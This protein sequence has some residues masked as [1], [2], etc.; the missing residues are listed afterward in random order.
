MELLPAEQA[1]DR[2]CRNGTAFDATGLSDRR[3][4]G[5]V[6]L[7]LLE[8]A[9]AQRP[10]FKLQLRGAEVVGGLDFSDRTDL[11]S[12]TLELIGCKFEG[13]ING[14]SARLHRL[15]I[16][17]CEV[18]HISLNGVRIASNLVIEQCVP[19]PGATLTFAARSAIIEGNAEFSDS[20]FYSN[21]NVLAVD[22]QEARIGGSLIAAGAFRVSGT[23]RLNGARIDGQLMLDGADLA[24]HDRFPAIGFGHSLI[25]IEARIGGQV[26]LDS[27]SLGHRFLSRGEVSFD[28]SSVGGSF[29]LRGASLR[30]ADA[31]TA[32]SARN[33]SVGGDLDLRPMTTSE[34]RLRCEVEGGIV[35]VGAR[36]V[37]SLMASGASIRRE[38]GDVA[39][40]ATD[41]VVGRSVHLDTDHFDAG[42]HRFESYGEVYMYGAKIGGSLEC[43]GSR[44]DSGT[45]ASALVLANAHIGSE[46]HFCPSTSAGAIKQ[47]TEIFGGVTIEHATVRGDACFATAKITPRPDKAALDA[48]AVTIGG[49]LELNSKT[50]GSGSASDVRFEASGPVW[51]PD[52]I[53]GSVDAIGASLQ[54]GSQGVALNLQRCQIRGAVLLRARPYQVG[55]ET[56][57]SRFEANG[58]VWMLGASIGGACDLGGGRFTSSDKR[59]ALNLHNA[60]VGENLIVGGSNEGAQR[61]EFVGDANISSA[62]VRGGLHIKDVVFGGNG[63]INLSNLIT[64]DL[65]ISPRTM[66]LGEDYRVVLDGLRYHKINILTDKVVNGTF[67][68]FIIA[69]ARPFFSW[70]AKYTYLERNGIGDR[71]AHIQSRFFGTDP[72]WRYGLG[73][74]DMMFSGVR[75][76][77]SE[78]TPQPFMQMAKVLRHDGDY[79]G[80]RR[81]LSRKNTIER[82][83]SH[84]PGRQIMFGYWALFDYGL[85][86]RRA[87]I[88]LLVSLAIGALGVEIARN[89]ASAIFVTRDPATLS[90]EPWLVRELSPPSSAEVEKIDLPLA[91]EEPCGKFVD[92]TLYAADVFFPLIDLRQ[93]QRCTISSQDS[94][95]PW[96]WAKALYAIVGWIV[97]SLTILTFSGFAR[98]RAGTQTD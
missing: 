25:A 16:S 36:I 31:G 4:R 87:L 55:D 53:I 89:P 2:Q 51:C 70:S 23:L 26:S 8:K 59:A 66:R 96:R 86:E 7:Q 14:D 52:A 38:D 45:S 63:A 33:I 17:Q 81:I 9:L 21:S 15:L 58:S 64:G 35:L 49:A 78:Y 97:V 69:I 28:S 71:L 90:S 19:S 75:P 39:V 62:S 77:L 92:P 56:H 20:T 72:S 10:A 11:D 85:S 61:T 29:S 18:A 5:T 42:D 24:T 44:M 1:L 13:W 80:S 60:T 95:W 34:G 65:I 83:L 79:E 12:V 68:K 22:F 74:L 43:R 37:G 41:I 6:I 40:L 67:Q 46:L 88:T 91:K 47:R 3:V 32:F 57:F 98:R 48:T 84:F 27:H 82:R 94:A 73:V 30:P 76:T 93:E 50:F 54:K